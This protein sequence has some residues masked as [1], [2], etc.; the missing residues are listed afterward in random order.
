MEEVVP[1]PVS[2]FP[3]FISSDPVLA[4]GLSISFPYD[5]RCTIDDVR[6]REVAA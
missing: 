5:L 6:D 2:A 4:L 1:L 3:P